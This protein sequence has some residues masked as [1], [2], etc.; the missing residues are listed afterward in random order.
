MKKL[1]LLLLTGFG[2]NSCNH[3]PAQPLA[4]D[5]VNVLVG[6]AG[7]VAATGHAPAATANDDARVQAH[8]AYA[9]KLLRQQSTPAQS[10]ALARRRAH[11]LDLLHKY[12]VAGVFPRN[13]DFPGERRPCFIDRDGRLCA[14]GYLVA[15][16]AGRPA[17][18]SINQAHQYDLIADMRTPALAEWVAAS[19]LTKA[20]CA[21]I[22]PTYGPPPSTDA[23]VKSYAVGSAMW[24]GINVMLGAANASQFNRPEVGKGA[25][26]A[27]VLSGTG[28]LLLGALRLP[29]DQLGINWSPVTNNSSVRTVSYLNIGLGTATVA[30]SAWNLI[31]HRN[32]ALR[33]TTVGAVTFPGP[34]G[35]SGLSLTHRF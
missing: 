20:E 27:G 11:L 33:K 12:W 2:L 3:Q 10:P 7:Y 32:A 13:Y 15:E 35:G 17:A 22:Q 21:L 8:L 29:N 9:E 24:G 18:E 19:G 23:D 4:V 30:L 26:Y 25:A 31:S 14:V 16:T 5:Q 28:Q 34:A 6:N 1:L